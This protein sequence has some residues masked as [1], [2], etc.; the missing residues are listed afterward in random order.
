MHGFS[1]PP[2]FKP[3]S[4]CSTQT[5]LL[6]IKLLRL[7]HGEMTSRVNAPC[8]GQSQHSHGIWGSWIFV[9]SLENSLVRLVLHFLVSFFLGG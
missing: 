6:P 9:F 2:E 3:L 4:T 1:F 8:N 7:S 5:R